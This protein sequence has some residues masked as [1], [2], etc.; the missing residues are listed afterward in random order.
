M[1]TDG[2][3]HIAFVTAT[4]A[5]AATAMSQMN[6]FHTNSLRLRQQQNKIEKKT[7]SQSSG[8]NGPLLV[9]TPTTHRTNIQNK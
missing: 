6:G 1:V 3:V 9:Q 5:V 7:L 4:V 8:V 2:T